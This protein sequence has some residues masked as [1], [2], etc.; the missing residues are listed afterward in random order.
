MRYLT[1]LLL[2]LCVAPLLAQGAPAPDPSAAKESFVLQ[3]AAVERGV[4]NFAIRLVANE[5]A[6]FATSSSKPPAL[7]FG[8]GVK[9]VAGSFSLL[10]QNEAQASIDVE[11]DVEGTVEVKLELFSVNGTAVLKT[12]RASLGIKGVSDVSGSQA[13]VGAESIRLV[14]VNSSDPQPAGVILISGAIAGSVSVKA[15]TGCAFAVQ[16]TVST[17]SGDINSP[18]LASANTV[19]SFAIGNPSLNAVTV[20]IEGIQYNTQI[21]KLAGGTEGDLACEVSGAALSNQIALVVN[22]F[23]ARTTI[24]GSNDNTTPAPAAG[25]GTGSQSSNSTSGTGATPSSINTGSRPLES[26][27]NNRANRDRAN[28]NNQGGASQPAPQAGATRAPS[29]PGAVP[30]PP[31]GGQAGAAG[32][33]PAAGVGGAGGGATK[34]GGGATMGGTGSITQEKVDGSELERKLE[35]AKPEPKTLEV[36]PGL[37]FCDKD[38]KP[39]SALVLDK[40][41]AGEAGGRVWIVLKLKKDKQPDKVE[42]V[43]IKLTV[44]GVSRELT[45]TETGKNTGEFRCGKEGILVVANENPDSN[46]EDKEAEPP[47]P[48]FD[49]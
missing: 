19:F 36:S 48:R 26:S 45:L 47:K 10:N 29:G 38:F 21:F 44:A 49:R 23:T 40:M 3:P 32:G 11:S 4:R 2:T 42:T 13:K 46:R 1:C 14:R 24:E 25:T 33:A 6:G 35:T 18:A 27:N 31:Q 34:A 16:P 5:P 17:S 30:L 22:A 15:P 41:I 39:V 43:T 7:S 9:L 20:R 12:L 28:R 8:A 37:Y